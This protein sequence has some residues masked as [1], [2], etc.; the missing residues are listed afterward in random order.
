MTAVASAEHV[1][2]IIAAVDGTASSPPAVDEAVRLAAEL[3]VPLVFLYVR[4][5]V[6]PRR[7]SP[8][9]GSGRPR[10]PGRR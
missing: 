5:P 6:G 10:G 2:P 4:M 8:A 9:G 7:P 3:G 1:A